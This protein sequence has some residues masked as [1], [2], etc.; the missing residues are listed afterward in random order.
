MDNN[1]KERTDTIGFPVSNKKF[2]LMNIFTMGVYIL[3]WAFNNLHRLELPG[4]GKVG[5][6]VFAF[7]FPFAFYD[8]MKKLELFAKAA[9][10]PVSLNKG[11]LAWS[12]FLLSAASNFLSNSDALFLIGFL[13]KYVSIAILF[14]A[15]KEI[16]RVNQEL[17]PDGPVDS[18]LK[19]ADFVWL[20]ILPI[21]FTLGVIGA[22]IKG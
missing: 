2:W 8:M 19:P 12:F 22:L 6:A 17:M 18:G 21:I 7:F 9:D 3:P 10:H 15:Q 13:L 1:I 16:L 14:R 11:A 20:A 4:K 5:N